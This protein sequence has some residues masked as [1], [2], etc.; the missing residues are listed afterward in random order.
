VK[1]AGELEAS[2]KEFLA[3]GL[4]DLQENGGRT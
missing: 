1:F 3:S 4:V 2:L